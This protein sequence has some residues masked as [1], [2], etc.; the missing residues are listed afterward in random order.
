MRAWTDAIQIG[1]GIEG[2]ELTNNGPAAA[3][4]GP[5][6]TIVIVGMRGAGKTHIGGT[7]AALS[8]TFVSA[9]GSFEACMGEFVSQFA[10]SKGWP[11]FLPMDTKLVQD[12]ITENPNQTIISTRGG[13]I[14]S[15]GN[16]AMLSDYGR[17]VG[18]VV[19]VT[20]N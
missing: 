6:A 20:R 9:D 18:P 15:A 4:Y 12:L 10:R 3:K 19:Y 7:A 1:V 5:E 2:V 16:R 17:A 8:W 13:V 11:A 14:K